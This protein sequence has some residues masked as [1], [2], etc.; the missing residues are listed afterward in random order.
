MSLV[1]HPHGHGFI[2]QPSWHY[3]R[4]LRNAGYG[5]S[6]TPNPSCTLLNLLITLQTIV[7]LLLDYTLLGL[8]YSRF[9]FSDAAYSIRFSKSLYMTLKGDHLVLS[10]R[11]SNV[12]RLTVI[13]PSVRLLLAL[14]V[15][16]SNGDDHVGNP[17][18][19]MVR[20]CCCAM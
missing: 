7:S 11:V 8:V 6:L 15:E 13:N 4:R 12:R 20:A 10:T 5:G 1:K 9:S 3:R 16:G 2:V 18:L 17:L 19:F 14:D